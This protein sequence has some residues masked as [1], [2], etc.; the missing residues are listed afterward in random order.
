M[1]IASRAPKLIV[2]VGPTASGKSDAAVEIA[3]KYNGEVIS[4]DSRQIYRGMDIGTGKVQLSK[5]TY[6]KQLTTNNH[7]PA[8]S[9]QQPITSYYKG[10]PHHLLNVASPKRTFTVARYRTLAERALKDIIRR[11]KTPIIAGGTGFYID[12]L[13]YDT[14]I[15][16]VKP[17]RLLRARFEKKT[18]E[19]LF[20]I[21]KTRD[22][23]RARTIDRHNTRR[24]IR[25]LEIIE[26]TNAPVPAPPASRRHTHSNILQNVEMSRKD[27][28][29]L[30]IAPPNDILR[31]NITTRLHARMRQG[32]VREVRQLH[33]EGVSWKRLHDLG[34]EYR[35]VADYLQHRITKKEL[36]TRL[37]KEIWRYAKRQMTW[38]R[39]NKDIQWVKNNKEAH[40]IIEV[41]LHNKK[42][43]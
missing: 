25:A 17:N 4:A 8:T 19:E 23:R 32:M 7:Q 39:R 18:T 1:S 34:L 29:I 36:V 10:I 21:L 2:I 14:A 20:R 16:N 38:W 11:G 28:L 41:F 33:K 40:A 12:A 27:V 13:L 31:K 26:T 5:A 30:G 22:P 9:H 42:R 35:A 3:K 24:L 15:P 43:P 37:E 6:N